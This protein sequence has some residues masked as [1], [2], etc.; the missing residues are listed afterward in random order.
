MKLDNNIKATF[1]SKIESKRLE[2]KP[3]SE[4]DF[5]G[6][7]NLKQENRSLSYGIF[8]DELGDKD[9]LIDLHKIINKDKSLSNG[10][11]FSIYSKL[12]KDFIGLCGIRTDSNEFKGK[13]FYILL[14][15]Y[16]GNGYAVESIKIL[17][18]LAFT[19]LELN[20]I[21]A[22]IPHNLKDVWKPAERAGM[23]YM[24]DFRSI[25]QDFRFLLFVIDKKE[26]LNQV[27][28]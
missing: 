12:T 3:P 10:I 13:I 27:F 9:D 1:D 7:W 19:R 23:R 25:N 2:F 5:E 28:Y 20:Q 15:Q 6:L 17:L 26:Y 22:E 18:K 21:I 24:G 4:K 16:Q 8:G 14:S 11:I